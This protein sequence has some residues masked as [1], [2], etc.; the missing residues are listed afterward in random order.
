M[1]DFNQMIQETKDLVYK[2]IEN[3]D[4]RPN[5]ML[6]TQLVFCRKDN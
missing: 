1:K 2:E 5:Y 4:N 3:K 6:E